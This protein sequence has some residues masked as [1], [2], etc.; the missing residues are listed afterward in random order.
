MI[1]LSRSEAQAIAVAAQSLHNL[2][3]PQAA[4]A[5]VLDSLGCIQ[6]DTINVVRRSHELVL[7]SRGVPD[8]EAADFL[9]PRV[10]VAFE[11][12]A[13]A[14][15]LVPISMWPL[16]GLRRRHLQAHGWRG[17]AVDP[18]A[19]EYVRAAVADLGEAT[20]TD[21]GGAR[22]SGWERAAPAKWA[23]EWLLATGE[24]VCLK[25]RGWSRVYQ[26]SATALPADLLNKEPGDAE[27][28]AR[29]ARN[30]LGRPRRSH[31]RRYRRLLPL[32]QSCHRQLPSR[33]GK[34]R[35]S[36]SRGLAGARMGASGFSQHPPWTRH[37]RP[38]PR[39]IH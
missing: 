19:C 27:C 1:D 18:A 36:H 33:T 14:A 34:D 9:R 6:L 3:A 35:A 8:R 20:I 32:A 7:L 16:L 24:F 15:S 13:H 28:I 37:A 25:R 30:R 12:W 29:L 5:S 11:Y 4:G 38:C 2:K 22:G 26:A 17:P 21:L 10:P 23:A 39:S 31:G